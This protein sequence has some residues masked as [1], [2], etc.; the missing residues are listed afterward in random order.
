M[1]RANPNDNP[2]GYWKVAQWAASTHSRDCR[3]IMLQAA[4]LRSLDEYI[5]QHALRV[6]LALGLTF[7]WGTYGDELTPELEAIIKSQD[8]AERGNAAFGMGLLRARPDMAAAREMA[9]KDTCEMARIQAWHALAS[10]AD[11]RVA[12]TAQRR[13]G[14]TPAPT[15]DERWAMIGALTSGFGQD[16]KAPLEALAHDKD[17]HIA[18]DARKG[19][20]ELEQGSAAFATLRGKLG[21]GSDAQHAKLEGALRAATE[22]GRFEYK[23]SMDDTVLALRPADLSLVHQARLS[24]L[25]RYSDECLYEF[26]TLSILLSILRGPG[27]EQGQR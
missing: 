10:A 18:E 22:K 21:Q 24:V 8:C 7:L 16:T 19:L 4:K 17:A 26:R 9:V 2:W 5:A 27:S 14:A 23:E 25:R 15:K 12:Q 20:D 6:D 11:S 3:P 1:T 13:L